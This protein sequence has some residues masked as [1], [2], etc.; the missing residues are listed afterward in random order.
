MPDYYFELRHQ[1]D[2]AMERALVAVDDLGAELAAVTGR[3]IAPVEAYRLDG[4]ET[5]VVC[6]GS[7]AGTA[8]DAVDELDGVGLL[9]ICSYRPFPEDD[10][11]A[12]LA[13]VDEIVVLDRAAAPGSRGPLFTE[14]AAAL[15]GS[16][17]AVRGH[18]YGLGGRELHL[19]GV[20]AVLR[21]DADRYVGLRSD[22]CHA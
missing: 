3:R 13:G 7:T 19:D 5:A 2:V 14:V 8:K 10:V 20:H 11:R 16:G 21:G 1:Q 17:A 12:L 15:Y 18:V 22:S 9:R 6:M 4:A